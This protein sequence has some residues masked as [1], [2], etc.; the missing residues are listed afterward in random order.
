MGLFSWLQIV[1]H[2]AAISSLGT[3]MCCDTIRNKSAAEPRDCTIAVTVQCLNV[4]CIS[5]VSVLC[6]CAGLGRPCNRPIYHCR[7]DG[8]QPAHHSMLTAQHSTAQRVKCPPGQALHITHCIPVL[9]L[10]HTRDVP[11]LS[12]DLESIS[13]AACI[14]GP[15]AIPDSLCRHSARTV[16]V[17]P[18]LP[19][20]LATN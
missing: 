8:E 7:G 10:R 11:V 19:A 13:F 4:P 17:C 3:L 6:C 2:A 20:P 1:M 15:P 9:Q 14:T 18:T 12:P 5:P 16:T